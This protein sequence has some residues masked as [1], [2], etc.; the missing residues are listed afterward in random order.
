MIL[1]GLAVSA[2]A[3]IDADAASASTARCS[4]RHGQREGRTA[5][6]C[7]W[8][9]CSR[10]T[11]LSPRMGDHQ[12]P[13]LSQPASVTPSRAMQMIRWAFMPPVVA[14]R[15]AF[16]SADMTSRARRLDLKP[17]VEIILPQIS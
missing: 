1:M 15:S 4:R 8:G 14:R 10:H 16:G 2:W 17:L 9:A 13:H 3:G 11:W 5:G 7:G 6:Y 12:P